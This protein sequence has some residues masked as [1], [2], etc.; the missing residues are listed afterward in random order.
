[1]DPLD[2]FAEEAERYVQWVT[3]G[4][5]QGADAAREALLRLAGL[6]LAGLQLPEPFTPEVQEEEEPSIPKE[7]WQAVFR[8]LS[9]LPL[10]YYHQVFD[11]LEELAVEPSMG[12]LSDDLADIWSDVESGLRAYRAGRRAEAR[13]EWGLHFQIHWGQHATQ[14]MVALRAWLAANEPGRLT[15]G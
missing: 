6:F 7:E 4:T 13:W 8:G 2:A 10:D 15:A 5:E 14:A 12:Q 3:T 11:P 1:M 9:R